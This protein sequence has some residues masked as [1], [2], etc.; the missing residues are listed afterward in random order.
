MK[1]AEGPAI[2]IAGVHNNLSDTTLTLKG[3]P[4]DLC[5][6]DNVQ[7]KSMTNILINVNKDSSIK[8]KHRTINFWNS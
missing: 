2:N 7:D 5:F 4:R 1:I 6:A 3:Y 8:K